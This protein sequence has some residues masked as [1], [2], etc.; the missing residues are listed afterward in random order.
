MKTIRP[1]IAVLS[2]FFHFF[3]VNQEQTKINVI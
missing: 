3:V 1:K 2:I